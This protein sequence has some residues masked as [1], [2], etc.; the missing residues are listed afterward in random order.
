MLVARVG[1]AF[2]PYQYPCITMVT[3]SFSSLVA[4]VISAALP[5]LPGV[6]HS[7]MGDE[8]RTGRANSHNLTQHAVQEWQT[9]PVTQRRGAVPTQ[10]LI[11]LGV[12][13]PLHLQQG[14][15]N[16]VCLE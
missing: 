16:A 13:T 6:L 2:L 7:N 5:W 4:L 15:K 12:K 8:D 3:R 14:S 9:G 11:H 1:F 10:T